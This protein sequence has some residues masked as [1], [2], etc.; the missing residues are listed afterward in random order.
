MHVPWGWTPLRYPSDG[1]EF[2]LSRASVRSWVDAGRD[3]A[4]RLVRGTNDFASMT[5]M[6]GAVPS[7]NTS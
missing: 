1:I 4:G 7:L 2:H 3:I 6:D 5:E